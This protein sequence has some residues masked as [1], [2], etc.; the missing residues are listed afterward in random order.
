M[1]TSEKEVKDAL[2]IILGDRKAY[3]TSLNYAVEYVRT[4]VYMCGEG[5]RVQCLYIL[6]NISHWRHPKAKE[7]RTILKNFT[8][9]K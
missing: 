3:K 5:L 4:G 8:K 7:V 6:N 2:A 1:A 9:G